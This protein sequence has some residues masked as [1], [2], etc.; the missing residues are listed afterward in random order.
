MAMDKMTPIGKV[1]K[2]IGLLSNPPYEYK[3]TE[4]S[5][6][7]GINRSTVHRILNELSSDG[8]VIQDRINKKFKIGPM[9][10]HAGSVYLNNNNYKNKII[11]ILNDVSE[12]CKES[13]GFSVRENDKVISLFEI[14]FYQPLKLNYHPGQFYPMNRGC[15]GKCL[16][17]YYDEKRVKELLNISSFEKLCP[18]TLTQKD[19]ILGEYELIRNKGYVVSDEEIAPY[20]VGVGVPVR[21]VKGEVSA[22]LAAAFIKGPD[23]LEKINRFKDIFKEGAEEMSKYIL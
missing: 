10:Y 19:E 16:M 8:W 4:V 22:C 21:N 15:Y 18:N 3:V 2:L 5:E 14:E 6:L 20:L 13:V 17:A 12:K 23:Y 11:E 9:T 1:M 7:S